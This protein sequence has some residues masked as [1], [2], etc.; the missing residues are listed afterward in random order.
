MSFE[1]SA[2]CVDCHPARVRPVLPAWASFDRIQLLTYA[3]AAC[4]G[5]FSALASRTS[6]STTQP[7]GR[8]PCRTS[9]TI[10]CAKAAPRGVR[11]RRRSFLAVPRCNTAR[12]DRSRILRAGVRDRRDRQLRD[13]HHLFRRGFWMST[14]ITN[15]IGDCASIAAR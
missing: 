8:A 12:T 6:F 11:L 3:A 15:K 9:A 13:A 5:A 4:I 10:D 7:Q 2:G 1:K 14:A